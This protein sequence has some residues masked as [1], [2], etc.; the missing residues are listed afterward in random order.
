MNIVA[1]K[2][3]G[4]YK[5]RFKDA[6][7]KTRTRSTGVTNLEDAKRVVADAK[8][9]ELELAALAK[10]LNAESLTAIMASG[11]KVSCSDAVGEWAAW[12]LGHSSPNTVRS[13]ELVLRAFLRFHGA[14]NWA[15]PK[16]V[17]DHLD[18]FVNADDACKVAA[19][20][21]RVAA[22]RSFF[23][24]ITARAW[25]VGNPSKL[26][27]VR[28]NNLTVEQKERAHRQP[29]TEREFNHIMKHA[30][31]FQKYATALSYWAGL[32][33]SDVAC[34]EWA[35][36]LPDEL[37]VWTR[38]AERRVALPIDDPLIGGG[39]LRMVI[40]ALLEDHSHH[41]A[42]VFPEERE[43]ILDPARRARLS[44]YYG[45]LLTELGIEGKSFH[46]LRHAF[47]TRLAKAG[48]SLEDIGRLI[49]HA[50]AKTTAGYVHQ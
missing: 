48:K 5:V 50:N 15:L 11:K 3:T 41:P 39:K 6:S 4:I 1:D 34:L 28:M 24:F 32:R 33:L 26:V 20:D 19:R 7:G 43:V 27:R 18:K 49:G 21:M 44:V 8:V 16:L 10:T 29:V 2:D 42:Y 35:S 47:A 46:C 36:I 14:D 38:K 30:E 31:G 23:D 17:F 13:Q 9:K 37:V 12:R 22:L 40:M 45:R 25:Y